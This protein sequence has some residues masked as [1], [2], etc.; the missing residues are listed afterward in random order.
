MTKKNVHVS[1]STAKYDLSQFDNCRIAVVLNPGQDP[2]VGNASFQRDDSMGNILR[3]AID[4]ELGNPEIIIRESTWKGRII[5]DLKFGC[6]YSLI[7]DAD[8]S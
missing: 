4:G 2:L 5:P 3:I 6:D 8:V 1:T 7:V